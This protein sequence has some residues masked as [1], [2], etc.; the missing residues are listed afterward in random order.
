[1]LLVSTVA[2]RRSLRPCEAGACTLR[3]LRIPH[4]H[5][6]ISVLDTSWTY[7]KEANRCDKA[8]VLRACEALDGALRKAGLGERATTLSV[9]LL[10]RHLDGLLGYLSLLLVLRSS[11]EHG[12]G[13]VLSCLWWREM[14]WW[15]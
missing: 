1:M 10:R 2:R 6:I 5:L 15:C 9:E 11:T 12:N 14:S 13:D 3:R 4:I 7:S 8:S